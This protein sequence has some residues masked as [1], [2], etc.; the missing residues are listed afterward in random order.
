MHKVLPGKGVLTMLR[1]PD[2]TK[3]TH[4]PFQR[5]S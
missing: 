3:Y 1:L 2:Y 5:N 4:T